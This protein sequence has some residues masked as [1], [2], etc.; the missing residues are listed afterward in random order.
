[1]TMIHVLIKL[2]GK[3]SIEYHFLTVYTKF[4]NIFEQSL[5]V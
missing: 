1:M 4:K 5:I 3:K 2:H